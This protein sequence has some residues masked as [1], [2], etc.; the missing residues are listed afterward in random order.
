[1]NIE[2]GRA[3]VNTIRVARVSRANPDTHTV[4]VVFLDDG[5]F[6]SGV[7]LISSSGSQQHGRAFVPEVDIPPAPNERWDVMLSETVDTLA[8]VGYAGRLPFCLGFL[9]PPGD[10]LGFAGG[11]KDNA[12]NH[13]NRLIE[14]HPSDLYFTI[15]D[16]AQMGW[17]HPS[18]DAAI[19]MTRADAKR[20]LEIAPRSD[21]NRLWEIKRNTD[22]SKKVIIAMGSGETGTTLTDNGILIKRGDTKIHLEG[23]VVTVESGGSRTEIT[24]DGVTTNAGGTSITVV[25]GLVS[26]NDTLAVDGA[27]TIAGGAGEVMMS[28]S[29]ITLKSGGSTAEVSPAGVSVRGAKIE[30]N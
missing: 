22:A 23:D 1:M 19:T 10:G 8:L 24:P 7:P 25:P 5:G 6:A 28:A 30:L 4:D 18:G 29:S 21:R 2:S 27:V 20:T 12:D 17:F 11:G 26:V 9:H 15:T 14:R 16:D 13:R 3:Q